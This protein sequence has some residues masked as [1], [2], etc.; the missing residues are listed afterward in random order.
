MSAA[1]LPAR[2][3]D[4]AGRYEIRVAGHLD[5]RWAEWVDGLAFT[6]GG[7]GTTTL[8]GLL[9]DQAALHGVLNRMRDLGVVIVAVRRLNAADASE[10]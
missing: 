8:T 5:G 9:A 3:H 6:H 2:G 10:R 7:D 4:E 1:D